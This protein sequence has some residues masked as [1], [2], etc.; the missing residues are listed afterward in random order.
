MSADLAARGKPE[1]S[2]VFALAAL[3]VTVLLDFLLIPRMGIRGAALASSVAYFVD[4]LL[5]IAKLR[6]LLA[7]RWSDLLIVKRSDLALYRRFWARYKHHL[8]FA[9]A[10]G[11]AGGN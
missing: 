6:Q 2:S 8:Q 1:Y 10:S 5:L 3:A 11:A 7:V 9:P 4:S